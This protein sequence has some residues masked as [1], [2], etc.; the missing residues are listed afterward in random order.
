MK[1]YEFTYHI[2]QVNMQTCDILVTY[3]PT[4]ANLTAYTFNIPA[5]VPK[6]DGTMRTIEESV[7]E[8]VPH[9]LWAT[10]ELLLVEYNNIINTT[11][12]VT[13]T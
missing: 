9:H 5:Y 6:D 1:K 7:L 10:Q 13:P 11:T 2:T 4:Q 12:T 8:M 3:T